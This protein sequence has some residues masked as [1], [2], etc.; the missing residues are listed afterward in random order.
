MN[1]YYQ[2]I[3]LQAELNVL[4]A[5]IAA[6][7]AQIA[8]LQTQRAQKV[9]VRGIKQAAFDATCVPFPPPPGSNPP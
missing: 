3:A 5:E 2:C 8:M 6:F 7:D 1:E 4:D 9:I